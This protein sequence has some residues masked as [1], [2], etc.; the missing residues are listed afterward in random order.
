MATA[1]T[2]RQKNN[3]YARRITK[4]GQKIKVEE[5]EEKSGPSVYIVGFLLFVVGGSAVFSFFEHM[6]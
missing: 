6:F 5:E 4:R 3:E 1:P 2:M